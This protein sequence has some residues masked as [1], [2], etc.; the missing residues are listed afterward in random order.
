MEFFTLY[1]SNI[2]ALALA[3]AAITAA[4]HSWKNFVV[5]SLLIHY[6]EDC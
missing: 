6:V 2:L 3:S 4:F 5:V 1:E